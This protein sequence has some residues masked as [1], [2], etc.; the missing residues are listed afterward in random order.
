MFAFPSS[1]QEGSDSS[2]ASNP[3]F[4][5]V[6]SGRAS[7]GCVCINRT[8]PGPE[9]YVTHK[10]SSCLV[11]KVLLLQVPVFTPCFFGYC[12]RCSRF[13]PRRFV[14]A[15][16]VW[17]LHTVG[18]LYT[19]AVAAGVGAFKL[20]GSDLHAFAALDFSE[21]L[22]GVN[23]TERSQAEGGFGRAG[24]RSTGP[25]ASYRN[26]ADFACT[27]KLPELG[28]A[29]AAADP[30]TPASGVKV[31]ESVRSHQLVSSF[32]RLVAQ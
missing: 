7:S 29:T 18:L 28:E 10:P 12:F 20:G 23:Q 9:F 27:M 13:L 30:A 16:Q 8:F 15:V 6:A 11:S 3:N 4:R 19:V 1:P 22:P 24:K 25:K 21:H 2:C 32:P 31:R 5:S 14:H 26:P 17:L